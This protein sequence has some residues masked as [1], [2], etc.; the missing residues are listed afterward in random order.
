MSDNYDFTTPPLAPL[1]ICHEEGDDP[2]HFYLDDERHAQDYSEFRVALPE[3]ITLERI[4]LMLDRNAESCNAHDYVGA[5]RLLCAL[6][7]IE[8]GEQ[9]AFKVMR[10]LASI[11]GIHGLTGCRGRGIG[12]KATEEWLKVPITER[13]DW[14]FDALLSSMEVNGGAA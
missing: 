13:S 4:C 2:D 12:D 7:I 6:L 9:M 1:F 8:C 5:H 10:R 14:N 3:E 11:E